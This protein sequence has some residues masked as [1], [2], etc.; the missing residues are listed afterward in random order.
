MVMYSTQYLLVELCQDRV[1]VRLNRI[2]SA[3]PIVAVVNR[4]INHGKRKEQLRGGAQAI[5]LLSRS[6]KS[7]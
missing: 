1:R 5:K 2:Y 7:S 4:Y 3:E 6:F